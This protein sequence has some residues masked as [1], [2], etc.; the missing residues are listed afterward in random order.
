MPIFSWN[1]AILCDTLNTGFNMQGIFIA[2]LNKNYNPQQN[3][4]LLVLLYVIGFIIYAYIGHVGS[5]AI[6]NRRVYN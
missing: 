1:F 5:Y 6:L 2:L 3:N 4:L